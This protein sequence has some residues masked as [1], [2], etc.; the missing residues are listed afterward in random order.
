MMKLKYQNTML[1]DKTNIS[2]K[3]K[4]NYMDHINGRTNE[5]INYLFKKLLDG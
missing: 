1:K 5:S 3:V 2:F 4:I